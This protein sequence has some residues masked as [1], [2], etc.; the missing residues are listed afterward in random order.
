MTHFVCTPQ[1]AQT[2]SPDGA[3][4]GTFTPCERELLALVAPGRDN[5]Q[6][7]AQMGLADKTVRNTLSQLYTRLAVEGR[8]Q[9]VVKA[10]ELGFG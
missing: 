9:A 10:R 2:D 7:A 3:A 8:P 6:I 4:T 5:L 1:A